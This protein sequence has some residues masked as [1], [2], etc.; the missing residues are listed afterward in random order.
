MK[1]TFGAI[2]LSAFFVSAVFAFAAAPPP[3]T[4]DS[5]KNSI[6]EKAKELERLNNE[7]NK[8]QQDLKETKDQGKVLQKD[9]AQLNYNINQL[10]LKIK[11]DSINI[12][13]LRLESDKLNLDISD[14]E[15][16]IGEKKESIADALR[17][18]QQKDAENILVLMLKNESLAD[19][20]L[21]AQSLF[22]LSDGLKNDIRQLSS[23][24]EVLNDSLR[25][26]SDKLSLIQIETLN[27]KNRK[28]IM[29]DQKS[30]R[31]R[32]LHLTK[33]Q[34]KAYSE[35]LSK[36]EEQQRAV[37]KEIEA[38]EYELRKQV[39]P[40]LLPL[41][42]PGVLA[43][44]VPGGALTQGYGRTNFAVLNYKGQHHNGV[45]IGRFLGAEVVAAEDGVVVDVGDQD[46]YCRKVGYGKFVVIKHENGL[47][48]L[49]GHLSR[50]I[51][52]PG[53]KVARGQVFAYM[54]KTGW[55][56]GPHVHFVVYASNTYTLRQ[57][58][59]CGPFPTG[60]DIDP[61]KYLEKV[62]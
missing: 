55:A 31:E 43:F 40:N 58:R 26:V 52:S 53:T 36:L 33:A 29:E 42:R 1:K 17:M 30:E 7:I 13:K 35:Q 16:K 50:Y 14:I 45:D 62:S 39:D 9:V 56:T 11:A 27:L 57:S 38:F 3:D 54:G 5:L 41:P 59:F 10:S 12:E 21:E 37:A 47:T 15:A 22:D 25:R 48:T 49:Y 18:L 32:L 34:E 28:A 23:L 8:A 19:S 20:V 2:F 51:V 60:G 46:L 24:N 44:P 4:V 6:E 61:M